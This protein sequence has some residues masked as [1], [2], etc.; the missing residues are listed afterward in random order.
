MNDNNELKGLRGWLV[1]VGIGVVITPI[2]LLVTNI[3]IFQPIFTD[4]IWDALTTSGSEAYNPLWGPLLIG[5]IMYNSVM[6]AVSVY[7]IYLFFSKSYLFPKFYIGIVII[8]LIFILFDAW[9]VSFVLPD[10]PIFDADTT[11]EFIRILVGGLIWVPYMLVS[12]RVKAT[13]VEKMPNN[14]INSDS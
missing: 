11:K 9:L 3:L 10:E 12:K 8:S 7:L 13:F 6:V 4:G 2:S 14:S 1:L 5:E